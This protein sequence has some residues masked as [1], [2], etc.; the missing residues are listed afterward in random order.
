MCFR[1][2]SA[3]RGR[4]LVAAF[5][6]FLVAGCSGQSAD[7]ALDKALVAV[8]QQQTTVYPLAGK[9]TV[10]GVP[11]QL[12][13][14]ERIIVM[15]EDPA[16]LGTRGPYVAVDNTGE[17]TFRSY[18]AA[19]GLKPGTYIVTIAKLRKKGGGYV[20]PDGFHNLYNDAE[21][22]QQQYPVLKIEHQAPGKKDYAFDL[23]IVGREPAEANP[24]ALTR[25][26][27]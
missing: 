8:G 11:P 1:P 9:V 12:E 18:A 22:N 17:F 5:A 20:G 19:D 23:K 27:R 15:L 21:R 4:G 7:Q 2:R 6:L 3:S 10:D 13:P 16:K 14:G 25:V 26:G 24:K